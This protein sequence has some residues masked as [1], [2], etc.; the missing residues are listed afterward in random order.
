[1]A[2][3]MAISF[4]YDLELGDDAGGCGLLLGWDEADGEDG[5][6]ADGRKVAKSEQT[7][8]TID[9]AGGVTSFIISSLYTRDS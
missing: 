2:M 9:A 3:L 8:K 5:G 7:I 4:I 1:M 6:K